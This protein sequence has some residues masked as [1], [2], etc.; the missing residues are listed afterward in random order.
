MPPEENRSFVGLREVNF[1]TSF[2]EGRVSRLR[3]A[4]FLFLWRAMDAL[5]SASFRRELIVA[6]RL[7]K[8]DGR[9][10]CGI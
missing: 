5:M 7:G 10:S 1:E 4:P 2:Q 3:F 9:R 6:R 8:L